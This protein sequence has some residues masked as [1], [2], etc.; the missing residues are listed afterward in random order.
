LRVYAELLRR[1]GLS[2][3]DAQGMSDAPEPW[4]VVLTWNEREEQSFHQWLSAY[5]ARTLDL[6]PKGAERQWF[7]WD[8]DSGLHRRDLCT[9]PE[10]HHDEAREAD[11]PRARWLPVRKALVALPKDQWPTRDRKPLEP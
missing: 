6:S 2:I 3:A 1:K 11:W 9:E 8:I 5:F 10:H 4:L 7:W